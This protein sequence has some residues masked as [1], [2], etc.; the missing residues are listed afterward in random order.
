STG[1]D[2]LLPRLIIQ[3]PDDL[4]FVFDGIKWRTG[5]VDIAAFDQVAELLIKKCEQ[6]AL[7]VQAVHIGVGSDDH[8]LEFEAADLERVAGASAYDIDNST[9]FLVLDD[10]LQIGLRDIE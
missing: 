10:A 2:K 5:N 7:D 8:T 1:S 6:Q 3:Q 9:D 4:A